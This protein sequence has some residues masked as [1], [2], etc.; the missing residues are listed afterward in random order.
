MGKS[1]ADVARDVADI[2]IADD[3]LT[4]LASALARGRAADEN[5]RRAVRFLLATNA[6]E[7]VLLLAEALHGP[8][9]LET[10]AQLF[11]L[12]LMTDVFP[13]LGLAMA[14]PADDILRRPPRHAGDE[15]FGRSEATA[16]AGDALR[17][18]MPA[19]LMHAIGTMRHGS[20][21]R[22]R[23]LTFLSLAS[24]QLAHALKLAPNRPR[25]DVMDQPVELG[26]AASYGMLA[27]P[28]ALGPLRNILRI[29][30]PRP[31][32]AALIVGFSLAPFAIHIMRSRAK[33]RRS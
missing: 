16:V 20:G 8:D 26:V 32:E 21:P 33:A 19:V 2:V 18:V 14:R 17:I 24:H 1:G 5:L 12:N 9:A 29:A 11:W 25:S 6:S 3:D 7:V 13:A 22:A 31:L 15:A 30:A 28:F 10:P 23:G 4:S 27:A